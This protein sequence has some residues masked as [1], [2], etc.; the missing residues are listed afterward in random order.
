MLLMKLEAKEKFAFLQLSHYLA[1][2]DGVFGQKEE[3]IIEGFCLA[4]GVENSTS[5][6]KTS[7]D[8]DLTLS[9]FSTPESKKIVILSLMVLVHIDDKFDEKEYELVEEIMTKF[10][11]DKKDLKSYSSWGKALSALYEQ[12]KNFIYEE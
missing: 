7:F 2:I 11:L 12:A 6:D 3:D 1:R 5:F 10:D 9:Q 4:M 8:L